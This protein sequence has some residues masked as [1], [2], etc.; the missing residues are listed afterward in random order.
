[1]C[2]HVYIYTHI[3]STYTLHVHH[4]YTYT[5]IKLQKQTTYPYRL[6]VYSPLSTCRD[7]VR[8]ITKNRR[9]CCSSRPAH[10]GGKS[11]SNLMVFITVWRSPLLLSEYL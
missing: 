1:M 8:E 10:P 2:I 7:T 4:T 3:Y 11:S 5:Y 9:A 6:P